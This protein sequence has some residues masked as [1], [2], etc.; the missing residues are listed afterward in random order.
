MKRKETIKEVAEYERL[1]LA[2]NLSAINDAHTALIELLTERLTRDEILETIKPIN[3][4]LTKY[5][6][7]LE[8]LTEA[9]G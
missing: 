6:V 1:N 8:E 9:E 2:G 4:A 5:Q 3:S 7:L